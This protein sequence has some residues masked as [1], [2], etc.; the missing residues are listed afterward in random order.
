M[1]QARAAVFCAA[2]AFLL[3][4]ATPQALAQE[5]EWGIAREYD[6]NYGSQVQRGEV[7]VTCVGS[8]AGFVF[9]DL[10]QGIQS[11]SGW[12][13]VGTSFCDSGDPAAKWV[14]AR[15]TPAYGY[16]E[17]VIQRNI[18]IGPSHTF[19]IHNYAD[20]IWRVYIDGG[21]KVSLI[22]YGNGSTANSADVGLEVT[23][24]RMDST[25]YYT[26]ESQLTAWSSRASSGSWAGMD[27]CRDTDTRIYPKWIS[28]TSW[29]HT[30]NYSASQS[31]CSS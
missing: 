6:A 20:D 2:V 31:T 25:Q 22:G 28:A 3:L 4:L 15:Y 11:D 30:L 9:D 5:S 21:L 13:E 24:N 10:W 16:Y 18:A 14:W 19:K 12:I 17:S 7:G 29:R 23:S 26:Y 1:Y 8:G 27:Y